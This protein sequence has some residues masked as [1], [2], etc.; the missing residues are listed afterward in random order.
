MNYSEKITINVNVVDLGQ[1]DLLVEKGFF[2]NRTDFIKTAIR[3]QLESQSYVVKDIVIKDNFA[4]G[5]TIYGKSDF[6]V[7][8]LKKEKLNIK[9]IGMLILKDD[10]AEDL[11]SEVINSIEVKGLFRANAALKKRLEGITNIK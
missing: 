11:A 9:V 7:L 6:E 8:R 1:I 10:I 4:L 2:S 5:V 3:N